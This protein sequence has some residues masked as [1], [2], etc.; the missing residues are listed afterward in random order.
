MKPTTVFR[1]ALWDRRRSIVWWAIG[2]AALAGITVAF[3]PSIRDDAEGFESLFDSMPEGLLNMFGIDSAA[4]LV[5]A[6][7]LVNSRIYAG[8]GPLIL[9]VLGISLG[10]AAVAG[11][12]QDG[13]LDLLLAQP[14]SRTRI[15]LA[16]AA[17][18]VRNAS[19]FGVNISGEVSVD[20]GFVMERLPAAGA[21]VP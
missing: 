1:K 12:E 18:A 14:V 15:V 16:K 10:T 13:T 8:I 4:E 21:G 9:A 17:A 2:M 19:E 5:T 7:G 20:F 11:E 3:Y 6:T